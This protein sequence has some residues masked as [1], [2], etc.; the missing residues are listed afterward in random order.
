MN[1]LLGMPS[2]EMFFGSF[3]FDR[4]R[5]LSDS[6]TSNAEFPGCGNRAAVKESGLRATEVEFFRSPIRLG[7][8]VSPIC[9]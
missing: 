9:W 1:I 7:P 5:T 4:R 3:T 2:S 8:S 6:G